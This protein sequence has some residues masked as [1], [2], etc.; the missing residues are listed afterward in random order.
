MKCAVLVVLV[1]F[2][3]K[4]ISFE[5]FFASLTNANPTFLVFYIICWVLI[6]LASSIKTVFILRC[7]DV[8]VRLVEIFK[9]NWIGIFINN[10]VP[11]GLGND[12]SR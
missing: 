1:Y 7:Y 11:G 10:F 2:L 3:L 8:K 12:F 6:L 9:I 5:L 4:S